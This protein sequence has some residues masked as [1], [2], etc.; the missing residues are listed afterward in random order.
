[1][2]D[3]LRLYWLYIAIAARAQMQ[4]RGSFALL[5]LGQFVAI[6]IEFLGVWALF[7]R[8]GSLKGWTL[9]EVSL[10]YG[11]ANVAFAI[12]DTFGRGFDTFPNIVK[13]GDFDRLLVRPRSTT[14]QVAGREFP[15][16]RVGRL[17][18]GLGVL[19]WSLSV[20]PIA[21]TLPHILLFAT[22]LLGGVFV[23][24]GLFVLLA[25][26]SFWT[27]ESLE[28]MNAFIY[29][30]VTAAQ[31]PLTIYRDWFRQLFTFAIPI[32]CLNY[33][34]ASVLL[35]RGAMLG[36]PSSL[37][38]LAPLLGVVFLIVCLQFWKFGEKRYRSTG[39]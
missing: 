8:F 31:Y 11:M 1:M 24:I 36:I 34:P 13:N 20:V 19:I 30:G 37:P 28:I 26:L 29:G 25:T 18:Q 14:L 27:I 7:N 9:A 33:I 22:S 15:I 35:K 6:G 38:Y 3:A 4:Y 12:A 23:F 21:W 2:K 17:L 39:S 32:A 10:V 16:M 5:T